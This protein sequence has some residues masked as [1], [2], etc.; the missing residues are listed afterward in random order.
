MVAGGRLEFT[1]AWAAGARLVNKER[2]SAEGGKGG[3]RESMRSL[4]IEK[5]SFCW[6]GGWM[7]EVGWMWK[8]AAGEVEVRRS[9]WCKERK[10]ESLPGCKPVKSAARRKSS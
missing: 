7:G 3:G 4:T 8:S 2:E 1:G 9:A 6:E 5:S 10:N